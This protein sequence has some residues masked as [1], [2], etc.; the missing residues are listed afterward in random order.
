MTKLVNM[1]DARLSTL[2]P[3]HLSVD[4]AMPN[5][6]R[7]RT[8]SSPSYPPEPDANDP[9]PTP[10]D[11]DDSIVLSDLVR[12][13][14]ASRLRRR[15]AMRIDHGHAAGTS[16]VIAP[17]AGAVA[18]DAPPWD[19]DPEDPDPIL[20]P[21]LSRNDRSLRYLRDQRDASRHVK[22]E[23]DWMLFCGGDE[24]EVV[25][26]ETL[27][28]E[29]SRGPFVP[30]IMPLHP[31]PTAQASSSS[32]LKRTIRRSN[33]CGAL[34][35]M[36]ATPRPRLGVWTAKSEASDAVVAM[37][38]SYF[39][40]SAVA[41]IL[42]SACGCVREGVGCAVCG[43]PLGTRYRP[44]KTAGDSIFTTPSNVSAPRFPQ[45][46]RYW[47]AS[48]LPQSPPGTYNSEFYIYTFFSTSVS[49]APDYAFSLC[50]PHHSSP[51]VSSS[52]QR[53][54]SSSYAFL[55]PPP[56]LVEV[57]DTEEATPTFGNIM[58]SRVMTS[59]P[60]QLSDV[61]ED[62]RESDRGDD[63]TLPLPADWADFA[64]QAPL[65]PDFDAPSSPDKNEVTLI[66][67]R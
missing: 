19:S 8:L 60:T 57:D 41:K 26:E 40:R 9:G 28:H 10:I 56:P 23:Y 30:S 67:E 34:V 32:S 38:S 37:S 47:H 5:I 59:S 29:E 20:E 14:E 17:S 2:P 66:P 55:P 54:Q 61:G 7:T 44:C 46:H 4:A 6:Y 51:N 1:Q 3:A 43:N 42:R 33:G 15:G 48:N 25:S 49:S 64:N 62:D 53:Q 36:R 65:D 50:H 27:F 11:A 12:T 21:A 18:V 35:H 22:D 45:G 58:F 24:E 52:S 39:D 13:G 31:P 16:N 63:Y